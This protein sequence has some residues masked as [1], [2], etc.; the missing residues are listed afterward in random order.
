MLSKS[1]SRNRLLLVLACGL[2]HSL[3][4]ACDLHAQNKLTNPGFETPE[5]F[6]DD[7]DAGTPWD[8]FGAPETRFT[9][10]SQFLSGSQSLKTFGPFDNI[11]GG[12]GATQKVPAVANVPYQAEI[13]AQHIT[14]DALEGGNFG[15]FK[16]EFL[17][18]SMQLVAGLGEPAGTPLLGYNFFES[19]PIDATTPLDTWTMLDAS[20]FS[21]LGTEYVQ[22]V[23]VQVQLGDGDGNFTGGAIYWDDALIEERIPGD[24]NLDD[25][26]DGTDFLIWQRGESPA[27]GS[28]FDLQLW[29]GNFGTT[30]TGA[31]I[32]AVPEPSALSLALFASCCAASG[33][34]LRRKVLRG[35]GG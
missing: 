33:S 5:I 20:G 13:F 11:G 31:V 28:A 9:T 16:I 6:G 34:T 7:P 3:I 8:D 30:G 27:A 22:A 17:D 19:A 26:V 29:E 24:F 1:L 25:Q 4:S 2:A 23:L 21:P 14:G 12:T 18:A 15:V 32:A 10:T 35:L